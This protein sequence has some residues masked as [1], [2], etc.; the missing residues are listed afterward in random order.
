MKND[1]K[2][3]NAVTRHEPNEEAAT[4]RR[5]EY[6]LPAVNIYETGDGYLLE[7]DMPGVTRQ[8]LEIS[9]DRNELT[10]SGRRE[11]PS[12][13]TVHYRE[14]SNGDFRRVF[15]LDPEIDTE[16]ISARMD[17]GVLTL[18]LAKREQ[19]KPRKITVGD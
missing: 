6:V 5:I 9:L 18:T 11:S 19:L 1:K 7:A 8:G 14:S 17:S 15:E 16:K 3:M 10:L 4:P 13:E 2:T 12:F